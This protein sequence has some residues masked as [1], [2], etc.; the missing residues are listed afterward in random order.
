M[1]GPRVKKFVFFEIER[2][3]KGY[4]LRDSKKQKD[5]VKQ[6]CHIWWGFIIEVYHLQVERINIKDV[7]QWVEVDATLPSPAGLVSVRISPEVTPGG[8]RVAMLDA[9][10]VELFAA[11][12]IK[13]NP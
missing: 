5:L 11:I 13:L 6:V 3:L 4:K 2:N 8:D 12:G 9:K 10:Q 7:S 1:S